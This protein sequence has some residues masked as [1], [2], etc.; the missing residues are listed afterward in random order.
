[1]DVY[2]PTYL[3]YSDLILEKSKMFY[4]HTF[5]YLFTWFLVIIVHENVNY[6]TC[7]FDSRKEELCLIYEDQ[8]EHVSR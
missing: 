2:L 1:M 3:L 5:I 7:G 4:I 8:E 6:S